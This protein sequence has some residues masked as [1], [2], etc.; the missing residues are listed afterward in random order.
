MQTCNRCVKHLTRVINIML[1][2]IT[3]HEHVIDIADA[4]DGRRNIWHRKKKI[5]TERRRK[6]NISLLHQASS[7]SS[8]SIVGLCQCRLSCVLIKFLIRPDSLMLSLPIFS[9]LF[10]FFFFFEYCQSS[11][12]LSMSVK[13]VLRP[14]RLLLCFYGF[15]TFRILDVS[16][17]K[18][19]VPK[20]VP[21]QPSHYW[22]LWSFRYAVESSRCICVIFSYS[23]LNVFYPTTLI[24]TWVWFDQFVPKLLSFMSCIC[25]SA[26]SWFEF[27]A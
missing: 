21:S 14:Y 4:L 11:T 15:L 2:S 20:T 3:W 24:I 17:P 1:S 18:R 26:T 12:T 22:E 19:F 23:G 9:F 13:T 27:R 6:C 8:K 5:Q 10:F 16:Y 7:S 25:I